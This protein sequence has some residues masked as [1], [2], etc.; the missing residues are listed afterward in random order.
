[1]SDLDEQLKTL[2]SGKSLTL[3]T[4]ESCTGGLLAARLVDVPGASRYFLGGTVSYSYDAKE[5]QL[6]VEHETL[7]AHGAV[8]EAVAIQMARG[9]RLSLGADV[10][11]SVTGVAGPG[12]GTPEKPVGLTWIGLSDTQGEWAERFV[13]RHDRLGNRQASVQQSLRLLIDWASAQSG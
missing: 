9:V 1:M 7:L 13:W 2:F 12:G 6:G 11:I 10:G 4:A 3:A 5:Q 8:S